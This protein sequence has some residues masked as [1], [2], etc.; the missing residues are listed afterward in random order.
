MGPTLPSCYSPDTKDFLILK[1]SLSSEKAKN[2]IL[3]G[4][5]GNSGK[6]DLAMAHHFTN[7][8]AHKIHLLG[9][10]L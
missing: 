8:P 6:V 5:L 1:R 7:F 9:L 10:W 2:W 3:T 4:A